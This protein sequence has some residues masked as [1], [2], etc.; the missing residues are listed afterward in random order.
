MRHHDLC[1]FMLGLFLVFTTIQSSMAQVAQGP[2]RISEIRVDG[3]RRVAAGTVQS[4][5][6]VRVGDLTTP[7]SLSNALTR[8]YDTNLFKDIK[9]DM[10]GSVLI[11][12]VVENPIIN[13]VN[14]E[15]NDAISDDRLLEVIDVQPRRVYNRK[16][17]IDAT[18]QLI[19]VYRAGGRFAAVIEPK[20][21]QLDENRVDLVFEVNEGPLIKI[22]S[23]AFSGNKSFSDTALRQAIA[24]REARW[25][26]FLA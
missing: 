20:I 5:L 25:W 15:G 19:D 11:V 3:N 2:V 8:L 10:D 1:G 16:V 21:I 17:A 9:M 12:R 18:R 4:Y 6:P 22:N 7:G 24:S 13:R 14:I 26:A 23:I